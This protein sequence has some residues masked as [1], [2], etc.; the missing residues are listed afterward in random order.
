MNPIKFC[1]EAL[2]ELKKSAWLPRQQA[3][4]STV[5]VVVL[6]ALMSAFISSVDLL[7]SV[8]LGSFLGSR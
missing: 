1:Q 6:V 8:V 5:V 4:G 7:L 2:S 3:V